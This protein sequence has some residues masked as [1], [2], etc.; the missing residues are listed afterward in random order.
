MNRTRLATCLASTLLLLAMTPAAA[1]ERELD[2]LAG[3]QAGR[4]GQLED[5]PIA[6][7]ER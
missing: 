2:E 6:D 1:A 4:V 7:V 3:L 5:R